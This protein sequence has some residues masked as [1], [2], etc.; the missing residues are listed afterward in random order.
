M[1][2]ANLNPAQTQIVICLIRIWD[3]WPHMHFNTLVHNL[4]QMYAED[5]SDLGLTMEIKVGEAPF[6]TKI[7]HIGD[8][9]ILDGPFSDW[10]QDFCV[11]NGIQGDKHD[12]KI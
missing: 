4:Q 2:D 6:E 12:N 5:N 10:L 7:K 1:Q 9:R 8:S 11:K 3:K